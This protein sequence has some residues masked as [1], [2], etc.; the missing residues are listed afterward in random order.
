MASMEETRLLPGVHWMRAIETVNGIRLSGEN[1]RGGAAGRIPLD[2]AVD[3]LA[4][5][6]AS[7]Q[8]LVSILHP[9]DVE[10]LLHTPRHWV[11]QSGDGAAVRLVA[12]VMAELDSRKRAFTRL[13][14]ALTAVID[15][16][17]D[18]PG[19]IVFLDTNVFL[20]FPERFQDID[21]PLLTGASEAVHVV[22]PLV[23]VDELDRLKRNHNTKTRARTSLRE[24]RGRLVDTGA[25]QYVSLDRQGVTQTT[26][27][28]LLLDPVG[29]V[30]LSRP[31]EEILDQASQL[32][33]IL[34]RPVRVLTMDDGMYFRGRVTGVDVQFLT[35]ADDD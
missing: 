35:R 19:L 32:A 25:E 34:Q 6:E 33:N 12:L 26:T 31:D 8:Q 24:L 3:Y 10:A 13:L 9:A 16:W 7:E 4:W 28:Q 23:V 17:L 15:R 18:R 1:L 30:R 27:L 2:L 14:D 29:H 22:V 11:I 5:V 21:W 20:E